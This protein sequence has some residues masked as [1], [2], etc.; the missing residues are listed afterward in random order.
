MTSPA[1]HFWGQVPL[2]WAALRW[3][4]AALPTTYAKCPP[5]MLSLTARPR[6]R[7]RRLVPLSRSSLSCRV[8]R[9]QPRSPRRRTEAWR[10]QVRLSRLERLGPCLRLPLR[11]SLTERPHRRWR[12]LVPSSRSSLGC[13]VGRPPPRSPRRRTEA[14]RLRVRLSRLGRLGLCFRLSPMP[15]LTARPRRR[16]RRLAPLGMSSLG[17]RVSRLHSRSLRRQTEA[18]RLQVRLSRLG[19]LSLC[20]RLLLRLSLTARS[21]RRRR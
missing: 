19:R 5:P 20:L 12:R 14:G 16:W 21:R 3:I 6:R 4:A 13:R 18:W 11:L 8:G 15:S 1:T 10:L 2:H 7:W 9:P 17:C